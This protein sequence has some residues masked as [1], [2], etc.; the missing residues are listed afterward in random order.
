[1]AGGFLLRPGE[2]KEDAPR[3][4]SNS[5]VRKEKQWTR[6]RNPLHNQIK[7]FE[8]AA[9]RTLPAMTAGIEVYRNLLMIRRGNSLS[10]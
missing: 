10:V 5:S 6:A 7:D 8:I 1:M 2:R 9:S 4:I 3:Y